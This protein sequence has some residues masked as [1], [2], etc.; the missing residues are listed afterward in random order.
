MNRLGSGEMVCGDALVEATVSGDFFNGRFAPRAGGG[1]DNLA[2]KDLL[3]DP[4]DRAAVKAL[5]NC[6]I[7]FIYI[8]VNAKNKNM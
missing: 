3:R 8:R 6:R 2:A 5:A 7:M 1:V 4:A